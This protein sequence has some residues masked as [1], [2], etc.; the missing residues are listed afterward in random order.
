MIEV[1]PEL[2]SGAL[3]PGGPSLPKEGRYQDL[4]FFR[5]GGAWAHSIAESALRWGGVALRRAMAS[6]WSRR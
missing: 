5:R 4:M 3:K 1:V 6:I 2:E